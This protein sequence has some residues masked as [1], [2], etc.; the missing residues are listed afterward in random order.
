MLIPFVSYSVDFQS[1]PKGKIG[2]A[3]YIAGCP[4]RCPGCHSPDLQEVTSSL[5]KWFEASE[6]ARGIEDRASLGLIESVIYL[7]GDWM[8]QPEAYLEVATYAKNDLGLEN[9][10]YTGYTF[11][12]LSEEV[13]HIS[14]WIIDGVYDETR[15][16]E[17]P[18]SSNQRVFYKGIRQEF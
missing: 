12:Q 5:V 9:V 10:L 13:R 15:K 3:L 18:A 16:S 11:E 6:I 1:H 17:F 4:H 8:T 7:G 14:T 2:L